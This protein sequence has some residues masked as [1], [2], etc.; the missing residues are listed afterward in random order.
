MAILT[1]EAFDFAEME[2]E[3]DWDGFIRDSEPI[4]DWEELE[5]IE[6]WESHLDWEGKFKGK[7]V[8]GDAG[9]FP[10]DPEPIEVPESGIEDW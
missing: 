1:Q 3:K 8:Y 6:D 4:V 10:D 9:R 2:E 5:A 7:K